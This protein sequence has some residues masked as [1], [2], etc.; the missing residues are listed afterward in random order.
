MKAFLMWMLMAV[1]SVIVGSKATAGVVYPNGSLDL[2]ICFAN[3][4]MNELLSVDVYAKDGWWHNQFAQ[5]S[6]EISK[7]TGGYCRLGRLKVVDGSKLKIADVLILPEY[8]GAEASLNEPF[9]GNLKGTI[10]YSLYP[11]CISI[12]R[13]V[14]EF[15]HYLMG[16]GDQY[17]GYLF[18][19][20]D[21][22]HYHVKGTK[23]F[24]RSKINGNCPTDDRVTLGTTYQKYSSFSGAKLSSGM[25]ADSV[26]NHGCIMTGSKFAGSSISLCTEETAINRL[27]IDRLGHSI[28]DKE[29]PFYYHS[30]QMNLHRCACRTL[31]D[32]E[33]RKHNFER[34]ENPEKPEWVIEEDLEQSVVICIDVSGSM[35]TGSRLAHAKASAKSA[36]NRL[37][38]K[39]RV[40]LMTFT[41]SANVLYSMANATDEVKAAIREKIDGLR[42]SGGTRMWGA[43]QT[44][45]NLLINDGR[46]GKRNVVLCS[47]GET[48]DGSLESSV[49]TMYR[50]SGITCGAIGIQTSAS[51]NKTLQEFADTTGGYF[52]AAEDPAALEQ[53]LNEVLTNAK[54][55]AALPSKEGTVGGQSMVEEKI[56]VDAYSDLEVEFTLLKGQ[57]DQKLELVTPD[58]RLYTATELATGGG[59]I[60]SHESDESLS[61]TL[62]GEVVQPGVW[63]VRILGGTAEGAYQLQVASKGGGQVYLEVEAEVVDYANLKPIAIRAKTVGMHMAI[64]GAQVTATV[65]APDGSEAFVTLYDDGD[66]KHGD[67]YANDG[68]YSNYCYEVYEVGAYRVSANFTCMDAETIPSHLLPNY[69]VDPDSELEEPIQLSAFARQ[70]EAYV[71]VTS[72]PQFINATRYT[73]TSVGDWAADA[74]TGAL[75]GALTVSNDATSRKTLKAPF[76]YALTGTESVRLAQV[77]GYTVEGDAYVDI[78]EKVEAA[79]LARYGRT[80]MLPGESVTVDG[81]QIYTADRTQ[82]E[83]TALWAL[84]ADP[85]GEDVLG[86][87]YDRNLDGRIDDRE[88]LGAVND[89]VQQDMDDLALLKRLK[90][91]KSGD[92]R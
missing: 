45:G 33:L 67:A 18:R 71:N 29:G 26:E 8:Y 9:S 7:L 64:S 77:D 41:N 16:L 68:V 25:S 62:S 50:R 57:S 3:I 31:V 61:V 79:L 19:E 87:T 4:E 75:V 78:T 27:R 36:L 59:D 37:D 72:V 24:L 6:R 10:R 40:A 43:L 56:L 23:F 81:I 21:D 44:A 84:W 1:S 52:A 28:L 14:H 86:D 15:G 13:M 5:A 69:S 82:P 17:T 54:L 49:K 38:E 60:R 34:K 66:E 12:G 42:A 53:I 63:T 22:A 80:T 39:S 74:S 30:I 85:P 92:A 47:D 91:W 58:G 2:T 48:A 89:W 70:A 11:D 76:W 46:K 88:I 32:R 83:L 90:L 55:M 65:Q 35:S 73:E 20:S 51:V